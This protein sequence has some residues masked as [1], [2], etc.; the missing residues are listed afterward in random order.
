V[1]L[2][3]GF[4]PMPVIWNFRRTQY[5]PTGLPYVTEL[6]IRAGAAVPAFVAGILGALL[7]MISARPMLR[8][9]R[10][11]RALIDTFILRMPLFGPPLRWNL[12]ARWCDAVRIGAD[13]GIDLPD[14]ILLA[15]DVVASPALKQDGAHLLSALHQG[16]PLASA[17][18]PRMLPAT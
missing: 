17:S 1:S 16:R 18:A 13:A 11:G 9:T 7:L 5:L 8:G 6:L 12:V 2:Y 10:G 4:K 15:E 14:A 3:E